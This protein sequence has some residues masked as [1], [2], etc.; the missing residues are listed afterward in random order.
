MDEEAELLC[1]AAAAPEPR[2]RRRA[3]MAA[4]A[5]AAA[6]A[7]AL[8]G[9][10]SMGSAPLAAGLAGNAIGLGSAAPAPRTLPPGAIAG[11]YLTNSPETRTFKWSAPVR[12]VRE[13]FDDAFSGAAPWRSVTFAENPRT[14]WTAGALVAWVEEELL[15]GPDPFAAQALGEVPVPFSAPGYAQCQLAP[16]QFVGYSRRQ[17]CY[18]VAKSL[19]GAGTVG[20]ENGLLRFMNQKVDGTSIFDPAQ[21]GQVPRKAGFGQA[22]WH[23]LAACAADPLL[24]GG[25]QGT[26]L[27]MA[28]S[29]PEEPSVADVRDASSGARLSGAGLRVCRYDDGGAPE[30]PGVPAVPA[31]GCR[32]PK[33]DGPG[34]DF[35]TGGLEGQGI[36][37]ITAGWLGGYINT[38]AAGIGGGQDERLMTYMPEV[39]TLAFF[40]SQAPGQWPQVRA[41]AWVLGA[42]K[43]STGL[44][45]TC[46]FDRP[47]ELDERL[48]LTSDAVAVEL[49]GRS[50]A[51]TASTPFLGFYS[52]A[53]DWGGDP[54]LNRRNKDPGQ[55]SADPEVWYSFGQQVQAYYRAVALTSYPDALRPAL[56]R[57]IRSVGTGPWGAGLWFGDSQISFLAS[58]IGHAAAVKTWG[59]GDLP[60]D[61]YI[62]SAFTENPSNQCFVHSGGRCEACLKQCKENPPPQSAV[63]LPADYYM[64]PGSSN[65]CV[66]EQPGDCGQHGLEDVF[67]AYGE[68]DAAQLWQEVEQKLGALKTDTSRSVFDVLL[69]A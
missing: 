7:G 45:G 68:R 14:V 65:A 5:L 24:E 33:A 12:S 27:L 59:A 34:R 4:V 8:V 19:V 51:M 6:S 64:E 54:A 28:R 52:K 55:R 11:E 46:R 13:A 23:Q 43:L 56:R 30:L 41:P 29:G 50:Y 57:L 10:R 47:V 1:D 60:L 21:K 32:Q 39:L 2:G 69:G 31:E 61:Y 35:M 15:G 44:D 26:L 9:A 66:F 20:Y 63:W 17:V 49:G 53:Q 67:T 22:W 36:V 25:G 40:L 38:N 58:W 42:R 48:P 3:A 62:Y 18:I 16:G 37:D